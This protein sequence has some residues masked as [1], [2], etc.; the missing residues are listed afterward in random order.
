M[1]NGSVQ[2]QEEVQPKTGIFRKILS[3]FISFGFSFKV[4]YTASKKYFIMRILLE[5][6]LAVQ[7]ILVTFIGREI[8][9]TL[10]SF[11]GGTDYHRNIIFLAQLLGISLTFQIAGSVL[12]KINEFCT[13]IHQDMLNNFID[14]QIAEKTS[15]LDI[16]FFDSP[17]FHNELTNARRD[18]QAVPSLAW[19]VVTI[20]RSSIQMV[21]TAI[22]LAQLNIY[23]PILI[24]ILN[25]PTV[26]T[27]RK[28][29]L[30]LYN[31]TRRRVPEQRRMSYLLNILTGAAYAKDTRMFDLTGS[32]FDR[33]RE[34][35]DSW[36]K[37]KKN[38]SLKRG[39]YTT[40]TN[41]IPQLALIGI[42]LYLGVEIVYGRLK[43]GDYT[44]YNGI[45]H[46]LTSSVTSLISSIA[47]VY[48]YDLK[49]SNYRAFLETQPTVFDTGSLTPS[50]IPSIEF[51]N[52]SFKYPG[53][54]KYVLNNV[55]FAIKPGE[56]IAL[57]GL[58]GA[59]KSTITKLMVRFY[60]V[61]EGEVLIDGRNIKEYSLRE[62]RKRF[63]SQ[64]QDF[65][66]YAFTVNE[67]ITISDLKNKD[68]RN[69]LDYALDMSGVDKLLEKWPS[70][71]E[72][73]LTRQFD[74]NGVQLSGGEWQK[75]SLARAFF[76]DTGVV[77][78]DEPTS[79]L[80]PEAERRVFGQLAELCR[81][82]SA[83]FV[84]HR[85]SNVTMADKILVIENSVLAEYG[86]HNELM[87]K[88]GRYAYLFNLQ[89]E[90]YINPVGPSSSVYSAASEQAK[91]WKE[92]RN[93]Q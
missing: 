48:E 3:S 22:L 34:Q 30:K 52:V 27:E 43:L 10:V 57:V 84:S 51:R 79:A 72:T 4:S 38:I 50:L 91:T 54:D 5:I 90:K 23:F 21:T 67:S 73:Y 18:S 35:W 20:I 64:F 74:E 61:D 47:I 1:S 87:S 39:I 12:R 26:I 42:T 24:F 19:H 14:V 36:F 6:L 81:G 16:S 71:L 55:S 45:T 29:S 63:T 68:N 33:F 2:G 70:G 37:E 58:N 65:A 8:I 80:D 76:R 88:N 83:V 66:S 9:N 56:K 89:A 17:K 85:L 86:T 13:G 75:I 69:Q 7:P 11:I 60:D 59:G 25:I 46:Q 92:L 44:F 77:I 49:I 82:K 53:T 41:F 32:I 15:S 93:R 28:Y 62:L 31:W 40:I 78:L